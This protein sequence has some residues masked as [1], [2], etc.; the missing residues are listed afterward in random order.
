MDDLTVIFG[1]QRTHLGAVAHPV[2]SVHEAH[3]CDASSAIS[4]LPQTSSD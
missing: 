3:K 1:E 2:G 4:T